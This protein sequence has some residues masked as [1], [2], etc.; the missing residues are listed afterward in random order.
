MDYLRPLV[1]PTNSACSHAPDQLATPSA[2]DGHRLAAA[3]ATSETTRTH[4]EAVRTALAM[5]ADVVAHRPKTVADLARDRPT[6]DQPHDGVFI[7][8][9]PHWFRPDPVRAR[10]PHDVA[11]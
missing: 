9:R 3:L 10:R 11:S 2:D 4:S 6:R 1:S 5:H 7:C 8:I